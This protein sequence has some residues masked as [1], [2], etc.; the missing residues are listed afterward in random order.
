MTEKYNPELYRQKA[1]LCKTFSDPTRLMIISELRAGEKSVG[2][3]VDVLRSPQAVI[4][5]HLAVLRHRGVVRARRE[6]VSRY[7]SLTN[8]KIV[9]ACDLVQEILL[10]QASS[11]KEMAD[12][13]T[14]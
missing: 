6:G 10:E 9:N 11:N 7:Y 5:R 12:K 8:P 4:S 13:L 2:E 1:E 3:M 14:R